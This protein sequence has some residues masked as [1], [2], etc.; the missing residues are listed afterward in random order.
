MALTQ[1]CCA[2]RIVYEIGIVCPEVTCTPG[3][4]P[5]LGAAT[6]GSVALFSAGSGKIES[7]MARILGKTLPRPSRSRPLIA[8]A[9]MR[10]AGWFLETVNQDQFGSNLTSPVC[11]RIDLERF[12]ARSS[13]M[14]CLPVR[15]NDASGWTPI[16]GPNF[17]SI[18]NI[19]W[20]SPSSSQTPQAD[21]LAEWERASP[22]KESG[23]GGSRPVNRPIGEAPLFAPRMC[24]GDLSASIIPKFAD[25]WDVW[26]AILPP[27]MQ[28]TTMFGR[29]KRFGV[30]R[31][32]FNQ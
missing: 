8:C 13:F 2:E 18:G 11:L 12:R 29:Y 9:A 32:I 30:C 23:S 24:L 3:P 28:T 17:P 25:S 20:I 1:V 6:S 31:S 5:A 27:S 16:A 15:P 14:D 19:L 21:S 26:A 10:L 7:P 22:A 4:A